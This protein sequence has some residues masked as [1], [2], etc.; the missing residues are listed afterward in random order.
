MENRRTES[1][2]AQFGIKRVPREFYRQFYRGDSYIVLNTYKVVASRARRSVPC[3]I[4]TTSRY[5]L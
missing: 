4:S 3:L 5:H 2:V 1:D